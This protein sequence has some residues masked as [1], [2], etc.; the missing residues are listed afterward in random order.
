MSYLSRVYRQRNAHVPDESKKTPFFSKARDVNR[1]G[2]KTSFFQ[3]KLSVNQPGD[4]FEK[5]ADS[6]A[7][8]VVNKGSAAPVGQQ[9]R[10]GSI[11]R[12]GTAPEEEKAG[13]NDRRMER[14]KEKPFQLKSIGPEKEK[15]EGIQKMG[16]PKKEEDKLKG[17][18]PVQK[19]QEGAG[20]T[21]ASGVSSQ[22]E[23]SSGKGQTLPK[24]TMQEMSSSFGVDF[25]NVRIHTGNES[26]AM[27]KEL[28]AQAFTHG[29]DIYFG[30]GKYDPESANG[31]F[32]LA[33][34]LTHVVQQGAGMNEKNIQ[35]EDDNN[36]TDNVSPKVCGPD[37]TKQVKDANIKTRAK[38]GTWTSSR[39]EDACQHLV[40][41]FYG[42]FAWDIIP[43]NERD[44]ILNNYGS[45]CASQGASPSCT[46]SVRV[47]DQCFFG[48]SVNYIHFG[49]MFDLCSDY[50]STAYPLNNQFTQTEMLKW[51]N[52]Y[53]GTGF[54]GWSTPS[55]NF[56]SSCDWATAGYFNWPHGALTPSGDRPNCSPTCSL[57]YAGAPFTVNW[58]GENF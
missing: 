33:H 5:E 47:D 9:K 48:G 53:K 39:K 45:V 50:Y 22:I 17:S 44:W 58:D 56:T 46:E 31:K 19:K 23:S 25:S 43:L 49:N 28:Q 37:I 14:D 4:S 54:T 55:D 26:A 52:L 15:P 7:A 10:V 41:I 40:S 34:E 13:T 1:S 27:N 18:M 38:F 51:I 32:L 2:R 24:G 42:P 6:V 21:V 20:A 35:K 8:S 29:R 30:R 12:L 16:D 3:A 57:P 11:Q 36:P